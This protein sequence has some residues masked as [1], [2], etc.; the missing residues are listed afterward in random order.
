MIFNAKTV[1]N[2]LSL[3][4]CEEILFLV[5][6]IEPWEHDPED[7]LWSNR[8]LS[9]YRIKTEYSEEI[10]NKLF[11]I[12]DNIGNK[13]KELYDLEEIYADL[14]SVSRW[15][16]GMDQKPHADDM[17]NVDHEDNEWFH[18]R[19]FGS[20]IYLNTDYQGGHTYYPDHDVEIV[21]KTGT[22]VIHPATPDHLHG[23]TTIIENVRYTVNSFWTKDKNYED[24]GTIY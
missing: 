7:P 17:T 18:H 11:Q 4:E 22:L 9:D 10:G 12:K 6:S 15:F 24:S 23:V 21:P 1:D 3:E 13:I 5:K 16:P 2:F 14:L 8:S 20:V 19:D